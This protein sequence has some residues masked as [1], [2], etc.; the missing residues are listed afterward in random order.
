MPLQPNLA[1]LP[2]DAHG[3]VCP[4]MLVKSQQVRLIDVFLLGPAMV[5]VA[6]QAKKA[7]PLIR[8]FVAVSGV[9]TT[10]YNGI[11]YIELERLKKV[12]ERSGA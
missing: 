9:A 7:P 5:Y 8:G 3:N 10:F 1:T 4:A 6:L 11:N 2:Q 12:S